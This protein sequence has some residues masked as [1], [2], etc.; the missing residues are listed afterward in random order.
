ME[1]CIVLRRIEGP[2]SKESGKGYGV[3][4]RMRTNER[5]L[6][7]LAEAQCVRRS[8]NSTRSSTY[9]APRLLPPYIDR[10]MYTHVQTH[11]YTAMYETVGESG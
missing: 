2:Q 5:S 6:M 11:M 7:L 9:P 1:K 4:P 10:Y 3:V 8:G